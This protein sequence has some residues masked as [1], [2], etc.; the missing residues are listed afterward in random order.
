MYPGTNPTIRPS[1]SSPFTSCEAIGQCNVNGATC[2]ANA[3]CNNYKLCTCNAGKKGLGA[4]KVHAFTN[5]SLTFPTSGNVIVA[6]G[7]ACDIDCNDA[8]CFEIPATCDTDPNNCFPGFAKVRMLD[9]VS[10][11]EKTEEFKNLKVGDRVMVADKGMKNYAF[12]EVVYIFNLEDGNKTVKFTT[13]EYED[14]NGMT[15]K[16]T[17]TPAHLLMADTDK[18]GDATLVMAKNVK[19]GDMIYSKDGAVRVVATFTEY[20]TGGA[21]TAIPLAHNAMLVVDNIVASP[22]AFRHTMLDYTF[23]TAARALYL[24][25]K[26]INKTSFMSGPFVQAATAAINPY[27]LGVINRVPKMPEWEMWK[28][29][30]T[31]AG[32]GVASMVMVGVKRRMV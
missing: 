8:S 4:I 16:F 22:Y 25:C 21:Y 6:P 10:G 14:G 17:L 19:I 2:G 23:G 20:L 13:L 5:P 27:F 12:S 18:A 30:V 31:A 32:V 1:T 11:V 15:G 28:A 3:S 9:G 7:V 26:S 29:G 24:L